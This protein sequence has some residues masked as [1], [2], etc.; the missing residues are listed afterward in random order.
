MNTLRRPADEGASTADVATTTAFE[1]TARCVAE[2]RNAAPLRSA[3]RRWIGA[4]G[5]DRERAFAILVATGEAVANAME[6]AYADQD[7]GH[8][9][10]RATRTH[11]RITVEI[12]DSGTWKPAVSRDE[13]GRGFSLMRALGSRL[14][15]ERSPMRTRLILQFALGERLDDEQRDQAC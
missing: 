12:E 10:L 9:T 4:H 11:D 3:M 1:F 7:S 2:P 13:R 8:V 14:D 15:V 6:H 5:I